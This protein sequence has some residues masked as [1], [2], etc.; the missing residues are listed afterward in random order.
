M[1]L[2]DVQNLSVGLRNA[3]ATAPIV[4]GLTLSLNRGHSLGIVGESGSGKSTAA[5]SIM[6]LLRQNRQIETTGDI[7]FQGR[8]LLEMSNRD[9]RSVQGSKIAMIF[10][11]PASS[12]NPVMRVGD[13]IAECIR[14]HS[15]LSAKEIDQQVIDALR[16]VGMPDPPVTM[17]RYPHQLSGGQRQRILIAMA[18]AL[19]P[20]LIIADEPTTALDLTIQAQILRL[21][22]ELTAEMGMS[23]LLITHDFGVV[24]EMTESLIV[25]YAGR[26]VESGETRTV[27]GRPAHPYTRALLKAHPSLDEKV[28]DLEPIPGSPPSIRQRPSGCAFRLRCTQA[29]EICSTVQPELAMVDSDTHRAACHV[30]NSDGRRDRL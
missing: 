10:Q 24:S 29:K 27:L 4:E 13:Q 17:R 14:T 11:D 20:Q 28:A 25:L 3:T 2:L 21:L 30:V 9:L 5:L 22:K 23:L 15:R 6:G 8:N 16:R 19:R 12:L 18:I 1:N 7:S 26:I